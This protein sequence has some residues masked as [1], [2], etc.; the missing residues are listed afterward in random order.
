MDRG[1]AMSHRVAICR[2]AALTGVR[3]GA[4]ATCVSAPT[5]LA[6][7]GEPLLSPSNVSTF[8]VV[9]LASVAATLYSAHKGLYRPH[10]RP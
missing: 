3:H 6:L 8:A 10:H 2:A 4:V 9:F 5:R 1:D 7:F